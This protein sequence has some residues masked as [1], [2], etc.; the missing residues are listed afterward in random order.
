MSSAKFMQSC[1]VCN[2][3]FQFG[4]HIYDGK[5]LSRYGLTVCSGCYSG[6]Y[7]GWGPMA[8]KQLL[9]H[10]AAKGLPV[11]ERNAAGWLPRE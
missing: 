5:H 9:A 7:D 1:G 10:L 3:Q 6:N 8:E 11:P 4:P 2:A